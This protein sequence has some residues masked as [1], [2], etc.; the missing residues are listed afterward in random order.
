MRDFHKTHPSSSGVVKIIPLVTSEGT[1]VKPGVPDVTEGESSESKA[2]SWVNDEDDSN[3][4]QDSSGKDS[5]P[6]NDSDDDKT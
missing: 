4:E 2:E 6:K 5:D 1:G 3:N